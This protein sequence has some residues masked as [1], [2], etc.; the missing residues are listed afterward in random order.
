MVRREPN[1]WPRTGNIGQG[2]QQHQSEASRERNQ[3]VAEWL[4]DDDTPAGP[5]YYCLP[6][7]I[8]QMNVSLDGFKA[9]LVRYKT[10]L[11]SWLALH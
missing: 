2:S 3:R 1:A 8:E 7:A 10:C 6:P 11:Q 4:M 5:K 9:P